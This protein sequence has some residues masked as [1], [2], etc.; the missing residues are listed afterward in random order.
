MEREGRGERE[1][2]R[3]GEGR[4][5]KFEAKIGW[6]MNIL[7][8]FFA[9]FSLQ[10]FLTCYRCIINDMDVD[11]KCQF[12]RLAF[13]IPRTP[14]PNFPNYYHTL[15]FH[16]YLSVLPLCFPILQIIAK[17]L[18]LPFLSISSPPCSLSNSNINLCQVK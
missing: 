3:D 12:N 8:R 14:Q 16:I 1:G 15:P 6:C 9:F 4:E 7:T 18:P 2:G 11:I 17:L 13:C 10:L 5:S